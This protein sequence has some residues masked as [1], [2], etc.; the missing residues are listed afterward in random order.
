MNFEN[1]AKLGVGIF[2]IPDL[3]DIL[4]IKYYKVSR[5][6]NE[7]WDA[8]LAVEFRSK[9][10]WTVELN[11]AVGFHTLVE[12][13]IFYQF[14]EVGVSTRNILKAHKEL[15]EIYKT[16]FPFAKSH[17]LKGINCFGKKIVFETP[18]GEFIDLDSTKQLNLKFIKNFTK[19]LEFDRNNLAERLYPMGK[20]SSIVVDP[21]HKFGQPTIKGTNL[22]PETIYNLHR[23]KESK[24]FIAS[25]YEI[26]LKQVNDAIEYCKNAA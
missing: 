24:S 23:A 25:S 8:R 18:D 9:Y 21:K 2:T 11:K 7:Y 13:Y 4:N 10:S 22:Y 20:T 15:S 12:F 19:K 14:K 3:A 17:I 26:S 1:E 6:L 16:P 5:L